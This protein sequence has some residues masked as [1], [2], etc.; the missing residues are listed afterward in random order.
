[1]SKKVVLAIARQYGSGGHDV[2]E[3]AA[4]LL[5]IPFY[6]KELI[7]LA[8]KESGLSEHLFDGMD[9]KPT[10]SLLY[11]LVTGLQ[12]NSNTYYHYLDTI[13]PDNIFRIQANVIRSLAEKGSCVFVGRCS[14]YILREDTS[15]VSV[16]I[17]ADMDYRVERVMAANDIKEKAAIDLIKKTDKKRAS[18]YNFYSNKAWGNVDNYDLSI[19]TDR[20]GFD[21]AAK[22]I[23]DFINNI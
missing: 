15:L 21:N 23:V 12:T 6:D 9:E 5:D 19:A 13:N 4:Q 14:D 3:K 2:A 1:M 18:F 10:N 11:S 22:L 16:F 8:A 17:H 7:A 20:I